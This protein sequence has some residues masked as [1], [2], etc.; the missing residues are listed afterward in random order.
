MTDDQTAI[1][2][3]DVSFTLPDGKTLLSNL[4]LRVLTLAG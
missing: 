4:N 1:E 3:R 2:F